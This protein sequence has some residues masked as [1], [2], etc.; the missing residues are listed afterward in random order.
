LTGWRID[1]KSL[2]EAAADAI[3]K[4]QTDPNLAGIA[5]V[6]RA[7]VPAIEE[8]LTKKSEGRPLTPEEFLSLIQFVDRVERRTVEQKKAEAAAEEERLSAAR[9]DI[10][11]VAF[12]TDIEALGLAEKTFVILTGA[13]YRTVGDLMMAMKLNPDQ[14]L[15][16]AGI[17]PKSMQAIEAALAN[18]TF[19][20]P[21]IIPE[22][23][24]EEAVVE[25]APEAPVEA[26]AE[27]PAEGAAV[28]EGQPVAVG[29]EQPAAVP[30]AEG[31]PEEEKDFEKIFSMQNVLAATPGTEEE[32]EESRDKKKDKKA[33]SR[34]LELDEKR[35]EV[36]AHKKHKR[37]D[38]GWTEDW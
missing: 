20:E 25:V 6:E 3:V 28:P 8:I 2:P 13:E 36:V 37:G 23:V 14:V 35:G 27:M 7:H 17:G 30:A 21:E 11:A 38:E 34:E 29:E 32:S 18:V 22:P 4:V 16:L 5:E 33:K 24:V 31:E 26:A 15:G 1:I 19:P 9:A 10:P 12:Q